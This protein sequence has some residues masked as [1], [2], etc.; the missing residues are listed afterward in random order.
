MNERA[1]EVLNAYWENQKGE[2]KFP[3]FDDIREADIAQYWPDCFV[4][5]AANGK[6]IYSHF[7]ES[8]VEAYAKDLHSTRIVEDML[9]PES[10]EFPHK[11]LELMNGQ[12][13]I[14]YDGALI[15]HENEDI[16]FRKLLLPLGNGKIVTH[17]LG[18]VIWQKF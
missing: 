16:K 8:L 12:E 2:N 9:Y 15:N 17:I 13:P 4:A 1:I 18:A 7:G 14:I 6:F 3:S 11:L 10:P 5:E